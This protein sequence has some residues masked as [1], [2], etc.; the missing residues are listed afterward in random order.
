[1]RQ[2]ARARKSERE[3]ERRVLDIDGW[4]SEEH[5]NRRSCLRHLNVELD[6]YSFCLFEK[7]ISINIW[8]VH[9]YSIIIVLRE[10][11]TCQST[12]NRSKR[13]TITTYDHLHH[14]TSVFFIHN[15]VL[16]RS[17]YGGACACWLLLQHHYDWLAYF[18]SIWYNSTIFLLLFASP[19]S[20]AIQS[21]LN[22]VFNICQ[23]RQKKRE[24]VCGP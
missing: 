1:M 9:W 20:V 13:T 18:I 6:H 17:I 5:A 12:S 21:V 14:Y 7:Q 8:R 4:L 2:E 11:E 15:N 22:I 19:T 10:K 16:V 23:C 24:G 3:R